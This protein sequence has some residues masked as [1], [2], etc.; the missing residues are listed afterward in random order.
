M[1]KIYLLPVLFIPPLT[2][3][4]RTLTVNA[5]SLMDCTLKRVVVTG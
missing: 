1:D 4:Y 3:Y 5:Y 2:K